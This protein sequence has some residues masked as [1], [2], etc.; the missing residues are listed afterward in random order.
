MSS[1]NVPLRVVANSWRPWPLLDVVQRNG[2]RLMFLFISRNDAQGYDVA[3]AQ[4]AAGDMSSRRNCKAAG[5]G[6]FRQSL[7][8]SR[9]RMWCRAGPAKLMEK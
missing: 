4:H 8:V 9:E 6:E 7:V 1:H 5:S 2:F 3:T